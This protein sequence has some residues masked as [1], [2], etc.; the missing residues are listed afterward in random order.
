MV[1]Y[2]IPDG[3]RII[4]SGIGIHFIK[5]KKN[6]KTPTYMCVFTPNMVH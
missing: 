5:K 2:D 6:Q 3:A 4:L 1:T